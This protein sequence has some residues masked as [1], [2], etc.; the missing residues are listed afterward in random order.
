MGSAC[1]SPAGPP[2]LRAAEAHV[3]WARRHDAAPQLEQLLDE[4]ERGRLSAYRRVEDRARFLVGC[5]LAKIALAGYLGRPPAA[6]RLSRTCP[7]CGKPH[8]KPRA[9]DTDIELSVSHSGE[10]VAVAFAAR[11][12]VGVDV[13]QLGGRLS[14]EDVAKLALSREEARALDALGAEER[15]HGFLVSWTR[16]EAVTK[17]LGAGLRIE[18]ADVVVT[19]PGD[20][21]RL[22]AWPND[23]APDEVALFDLA[24]RDGHVASLAVLG[25][26]DAVAELDGSSLL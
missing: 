13:E 16:K 26:C 23:A 12:P 25:A 22:L 4:D 14:V 15:E 3:W 19:A 21:P 11:A 10:L 1:H 2:P 18:P 24:A 5:A 9:E 17:A 7:I 20:P 6:I 8:G